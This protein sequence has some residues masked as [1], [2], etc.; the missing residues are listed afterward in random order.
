MRGRIS[1]IRYT[2]SFLVF[3]LPLIL[4][5]S[6]PAQQQGEP[7]CPVREVSSNSSLSLQPAEINPAATRAMMLGSA[8]AGNRIVGVGDHGI[9]LLSDDGTNFRQA[10]SVPVRSILNAVH[11]VDEKTGWIV[12]HWG[13]VLK[14]EDGGENWKLQRS[15]TSVDQPLFSVF[16]KDKEHGWAVGLWSLM[17][18]TKNGG[19]TWEE[20]PIPPPPGSNRADRNL[21]KIF[22]DRDGTLLVAGEQGTVL[23]S[24][25]DGA[26][27]SYSSTGCKG[28]FWS[29][30]ALEDGTIVVGGL[31]GAVYRSTDGGLSWN[32][33]QSGTQS[34]VTDFGV[35]GGKVVAVGLD[36]VFLES[37]DGGAT[38]KSTQR[39][40][41]LPLTALARVGTNSRLVFFSKQGVVS[42]PPNVESK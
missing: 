9:V 39:D 37:E 5:F 30:L 38:F 3:A 26:S 21:F 31:C 32:A 28:S 15:D 12:G 25:D 11:F 8:R 10:K 41:R 40:D 13:V 36:G 2:V 6:V 18:T 1:I 42:N 35:I 17:L 22:A 20:V 16:F 19:K 33:S 24:K 34:S 7:G 23:Y 14:T 27:W 4:V 29:G